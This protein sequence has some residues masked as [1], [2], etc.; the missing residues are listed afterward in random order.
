MVYCSTECVYKHR[1]PQR[2]YQNP[3]LLMYS[4][5][6][7]Q[8]H[9]PLYCAQDQGVGKRAYPYEPLTWV[10]FGHQD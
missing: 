9:F 1:F 5:L 6:G 7:T 3:I 10:G 8:I 4:P 2:E